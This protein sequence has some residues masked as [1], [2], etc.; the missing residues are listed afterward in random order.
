ME[1]FVTVDRGSW[2][3]T[4]SKENPISRPEASKER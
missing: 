1:E 2:K 4:V 3:L